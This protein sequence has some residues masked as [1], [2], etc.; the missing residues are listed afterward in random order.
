MLS[1]WDVSGNLRGPLGARLGTMSMQK[2]VLQKSSWCRRWSRRHSA[3]SDKESRLNPMDYFPYDVLGFLFP[4]FCRVEDLGFVFLRKTLNGQLLMNISGTPHPVA[5][6]SH[7]NIPGSSVQC[8]S[9]C[10]VRVLDVLLN[11][12]GDVAWLNVLHFF[13]CCPTFCEDSGGVVNC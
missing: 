13:W 1:R 12:P 10:W 7:I 4:S 9:A 2:S 5:I 3:V 6:A 8:I 11:V